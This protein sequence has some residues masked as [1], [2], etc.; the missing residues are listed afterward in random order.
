[1]PFCVGYPPDPLYTRVRNSRVSQ[2][3]GMEKLPRR[4][5]AVTLCLKRDKR[6]GG[7]DFDLAINLFE[8]SRRTAQK[9]ITKFAK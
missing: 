9:N 4:Y 2:M 5:I 6:F 1:M 8:I 7:L 3:G